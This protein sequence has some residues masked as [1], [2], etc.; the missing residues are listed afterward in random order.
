MNTNETLEQMQLLKFHGMAASYAT[1]LDLPIH[2]Q[3]ESH[4]LIGHLVQNELLSRNNER[5]NYYLKLA[6]LRLLALPEHVECSAA[7]NLTKQQFITL[8]EG[9]YIKQGTNILI[10]GSTGSGKS[11]L[12]CALGHQACLQ[13]FKTTYLNMNRLIEKI[14]IAKL[15]GSYIKFLNYLERQTLIILDDFGMQTLTQEVK[16]ALLQ[17]LEDR[18]AKRSVIITS[19]L[20]VS[21]FYDYLNEP[22]LADAI[23]DRMTANAH[24]LE[25]KGE[26]RRKTK[27]KP[28]EIAA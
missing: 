14:T 6:K 12:A 13:G 2:Q 21:K 17:I 7:R 16:L 24:R 1:Q 18:Y 26:S 5:T 4:E 19:Q 27:N 15:D 23:M 11:F 9:H 20:P 3:L 10:N 28:A 22:T 8:L 25:L